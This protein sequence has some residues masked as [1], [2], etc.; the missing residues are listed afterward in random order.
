MNQP[1]AEAI[2]WIA[3]IA[4]VVA[5][6][7]ILRS[8]FV[9]KARANSELVPTASRGSELTWAILPSIALVVLLFFT[10]QRVE[11]RASHMNSMDHSRMSM[12]MSGGAR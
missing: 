12:P 8:S 6:I 1:L 9:T 3:A 11:A 2:F 5:E 7:A 10:W 4:C